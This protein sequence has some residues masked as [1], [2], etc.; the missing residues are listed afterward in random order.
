MNYDARVQRKLEFATN[1]WVVVD[2]APLKDTA[3]TADS[4]AALAYNK[5]QSRRQLRTEL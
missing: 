5:I 4:I 1:Q 2:R 3:L